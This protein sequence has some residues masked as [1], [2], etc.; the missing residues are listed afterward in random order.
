MFYHFSQD[1]WAQTCKPWMFY[2]QNLWFRVNFWGQM[3]ICRVF[4][5]GLR[6]KLPAV[7]PSR[8]RRMSRKVET[9]CQQRLKDQKLK[10]KMNV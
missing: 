1:V 7:A 5:P 6:A 9:K 3:E 10:Q 8:C 2:P 4:P